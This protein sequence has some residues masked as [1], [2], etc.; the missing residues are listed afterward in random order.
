LQ[1]I[2]ARTK[3][4]V[5]ALISRPGFVN[6]LYQLVDNVVQLYD[7][8]PL[9]KDQQATAAQFVTK[10]E[11][12]VPPAKRHAQIYLE[13]LERID[14]RQACFVLNMISV[15][16]KN[17]NWYRPIHQTLCELCASYKPRSTSIEIESIAI[18][19]YIE[20]ND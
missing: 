20:T 14:D 10:A 7:H 18:S 6:Y 12:A 13:V 17:S 3:A 15:I 5:T 11:H 8:S 16:E 19:T 1:L 2:E 9:K 4:V